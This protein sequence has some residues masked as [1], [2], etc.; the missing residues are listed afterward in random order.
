MLIGARQAGFNILGN[1][2]WRPYYHHTDDQGQNTFKM[3]FPG[4]FLV[5]EF[6]ETPANIR[7]D[8][9]GDGQIDLVMGHP[10]CGNFSRLRIDQTAKLDDPGDIPLFVEMID[11]IRPKH[12]VMDDLPKMFIAVPMK[13]WADK[14]PQYDLFPEWISNYNYGN[15]QKNRK[16]AFMVGALK[17][18]NYVFF[19]GELAGGH[20]VEQ[21]VGD[22]LNV[23]GGV[24]A[25]HW[26]HNTKQ[27]T[28]RSCGLYQAAKNEPWGD[29]QEWFR[30][31]REGEAFMYHA[32]DGQIK[33]RMG[34][35][36][37]HWNGTSHVLTGTNPIMHP[38]TC[39]P[40]SLRERLRIQGAPDDFILY[41]ER[42]EEDGT[43]NHDRNNPLVK[44]TGK[45]MPVQFCRYAAE[46][47]YANVNGDSFQ[48]SNE[49]H[50][51]RN[52]YI[53]E[54]KLWYC[55]N[56]G[57]SDQKRVCSACWMSRECPNRQTV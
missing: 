46:Q 42:L 40:H 3:N 8:L 23:P 37:N 31:V 50:I 14:L 11:R 54:A 55:K 56:V 20:T 35:S 5:H 16:R 32:R 45:F 26:P 57:Y 36:K 53:D 15:V 38:I 18:Q 44:Q 19:P 52:E 9:Y 6:S 13:W 34:L 7:K 48:S 39:L 21:C 27:N 30:N 47:A 22:L 1:I 24:I 17:N 41:G 25:N 12:F 43:W 29:L 4:A 33:R 49:R 28:G 2:E 51:P 10:E